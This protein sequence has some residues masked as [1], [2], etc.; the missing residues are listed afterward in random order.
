MANLYTTHVVEV[1][2]EAE[3]FRAENMFI[4]FGS[5]APDNLRSY[6]YIIDRVDVEGDITPGQKLVIDGY[7]YPITAVGSVAQKNL[8]S[9]GHISVV[10]NG[11]TSA[12]LDG[13]IYVEPL[14]M[15]T[16]TVGSQIAIQG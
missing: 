1:G 13:T 15:P 4:L 12:D 5:E 8:Q 9:L 2:P 16:I 10:F 3:I 7:Q 6:C 11:A 14:E